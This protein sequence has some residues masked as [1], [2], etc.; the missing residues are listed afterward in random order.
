M[1][2]R[3]IRIT[4]AQQIESTFKVLNSLSSLGKLIFNEKYSVA[5]VYIILWIMIYCNCFEHNN[6][7]IAIE[8][9]FLL[10]SC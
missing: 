2:F 8:K 7:F 5:V 4:S 10:H 6:N 1:K 3:S 9:V